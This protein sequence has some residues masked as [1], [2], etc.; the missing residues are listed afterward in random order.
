MVLDPL[1]QAR[2]G[3]RLGNCAGTYAAGAYPQAAYAAVRTLM[4]NP[5]QIRIKTP[6]GFYIGMA[7]VVAHLG[8]LAAYFTLSGHFEF[9]RIRAMNI[10]LSKTLYTATGKKSSPKNMFLNS[11]FL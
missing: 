4:A 1:L 7:H 5:L 8:G 10:L 2:P 11:R 3:L 6:L 9:L